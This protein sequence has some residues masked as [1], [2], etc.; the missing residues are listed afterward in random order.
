MQAK[1]DEVKRDIES[2]ALKVFFRKG[3]ADAKMNDIADEIQISVGNIYTYFK[4]KQ[5]LFY[6]VVPPSLVDYLKNVLV[7]SIRLDNQTF[8]DR[9]GS[10]KQS[11]I[12]QEQMNLLTQYS[13]QIVIIF[14]KNK[15]TVY[16]NAKNELI[17]LMIETKK[18]FLKDHYKR[19]EIG[20]EENMILLNIIANNVINMIL[21]L[22]KR[23]MGADSRRRIF[24][25]LSLYWLHGLTGINE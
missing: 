8:F 22:L 11:A 5:E 4:N 3:F 17:E 23:E 16:S 12:V 21:D 10:D 1:K 19:Y 9:A 20:T 24:E 2:A 14:E 18:P 7:E 6:A 25:A 13:M 15:G